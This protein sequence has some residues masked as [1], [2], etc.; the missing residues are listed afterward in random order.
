MPP[1]ACDPSQPQARD[2]AM[3]R[4][5]RASLQAEGRAMMARVLLYLYLVMLAITLVIDK[6]VGLAIA[7]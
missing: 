1:V 2:G 3:R 4:G 5:S 7:P 6:P